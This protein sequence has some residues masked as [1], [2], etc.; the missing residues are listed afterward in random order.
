MIWSS[1]TKVGFGVA[2][3]KVVALYCAKGS[4]RGR[5]ACNVCPKTTGCAAAQ[6]PT[7]AG[8]CA[9]TDGAARVEMSLAADKTSIRIIATIKKNQYFSVAF[10]PSLVNTDLI[11]FYASKTAQAS[12]ALDSYANQANR[13]PVA[14]TQ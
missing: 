6:C 4:I 7:P 10:G 11:T 14:E 8:V 5:F 9:S 12:T 2:G 1:T 3:D 13:E